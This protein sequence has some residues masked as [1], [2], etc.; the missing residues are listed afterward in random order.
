MEI[1]NQ[2]QQ[3]VLVNLIS[4]D[5]TFLDEYY[6]IGLQYND[7]KYVWTSGGEASYREYITNLTDTIHTVYRQRREMVGIRL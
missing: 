2:Q 4:T 3:E 7:S 1:L 6:W 5:N